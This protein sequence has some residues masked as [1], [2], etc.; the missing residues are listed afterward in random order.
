[1]VITP[2]PNTINRQNRCTSMFRKSSASPPSRNRIRSFVCPCL[3]IHIFACRPEIS[4]EIRGEFWCFF[5]FLFENQSIHG[6]K[7]YIL[8]IFYDTVR[9]VYFSTW[10]AFLHQSGLLFYAYRSA[11]R[12]SVFGYFTWKLLLFFFIFSGRFLRRLYDLHVSIGIIEFS[13]VGFGN[14]VSHIGGS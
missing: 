1:M 3:K 10:R 13:K 12:K 14:F 9:S 2:V 7:I 11:V 6:R 8:W 4:S 5:C